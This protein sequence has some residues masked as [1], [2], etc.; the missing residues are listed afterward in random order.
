MSGLYALP[1]TD[2]ITA[3]THC[4]ECFLQYNSLVICVNLTRLTVN[5]SNSHARVTIIV[6]KDK[7]V[8]EMS[9]VVMSTHFVLLVSSLTNDH[10]SLIKTVYTFDLAH[11][12]NQNIA[13]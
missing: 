2:I 12:H 9:S 3:C 1:L 13:C 11:I 7:Y 5:S 6:I 10:A 4:I 8:C